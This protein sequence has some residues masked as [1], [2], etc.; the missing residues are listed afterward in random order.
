MAEWRLDWVIAPSINVE[1]YWLV[2]STDF[3]GKGFLMKIRPNKFIILFKF[4]LKLILQF[5][6]IFKWVLISIRVI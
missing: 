4:T 1:I 5:F 6:S 3:D 2:S